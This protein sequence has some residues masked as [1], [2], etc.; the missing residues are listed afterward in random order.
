MTEKLVIDVTSLLTQIQELLENSEKR[1]N[2]KP[3][4]KTQSGSDL[5]KIAK[6]KHPYSDSK[7]VNTSFSMP[8]KLL[9]QLNTFAETHSKSRSHVIVEALLHGGIVTAEQRV[10]IV[11]YK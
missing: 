9:V 5:P 3:H 2:T 7:V 11:D 6:P 4:K 10:Q 8:M 1:C